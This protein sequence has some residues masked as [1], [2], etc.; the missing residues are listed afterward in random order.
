[1]NGIS[2]CW[3]LVASALFATGAFAAE[4]APGLAR[5]MTWTAYGT[6][7]TGY[8]QAIA[9]SN[10]L[11]KFY[12]SSVR[13]I[14]GKNDVSRL[15]PLAQKR[16]GYCACGNAELYFAQEGLT[17]FAEPAWGPQKLRLLFSNRGDGIGHG[18]IVAGDAG[19]EKLADLKGKRV[20][21]IRGSPALQVGT[22]GILAFAGL[23]WDDVVKVEVPGFQQGLD[24]I[25]NNTVDASWTSTTASHAQRIAA[26][27]RGAIWP[28]LPHDD[29]DGWARLHN[30]APHLGQTMVDQ[31]V[32]LEHNMSGQ[33]P[34]PGIGVP[35]PVFASYDHLSEAEAYGLT[36]AVLA[37]VADFRDAAPGMEGFAATHQNFRMVLPYHPGA[38]RYF[39]EIGIWTA[40]DDAHNEALMRR[41]DVLAAAW[42]ELQAQRPDRRRFVETWLA[43][44]ERRL[45]EAGFELTPT[46]GQTSAPDG[47]TDRP[48]D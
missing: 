25:I 1:M 20:A 47:R 30:Q 27:P 19:V 14:P 43:L 44:R 36:R 15:M 41:Q 46:R 37:N 8:V 42:Q 6:T 4:D 35:Y 29:A 32:G 39:R 5:Q 18:L 45:G 26:S 11:R 12:T 22:A 33:V 34:F 40:S 48:A 17:L 16:A 7:S 24:A 2:R 31:G 3:L 21:W 23:D 38:V 10:T 9:I 28:A 13:V